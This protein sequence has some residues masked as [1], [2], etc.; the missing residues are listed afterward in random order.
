[1][2]LLSLLLQDYVGKPFPRVFS[3]QGGAQRVLSLPSPPCSMEGI[4][5]IHWALLWVTQKLVDTYRP[6]D[7]HS[8][9]MAVVKVTQSTDHRRDTPGGYWMENMEGKQSICGARKGQR[10][11]QAAKGSLT[12][13]DQV[14][15]GPEFCQLQ[16]SASCRRQQN[17]WRK[18]GV[19][20]LRGVEVAGADAED[21]VGPSRCASSPPALLRDHTS[22]P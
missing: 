8:P 7:C 5:M 9:G 16:S 19:T 4:H 3:C 14:E 6:Q 21:S 2:R 22:L 1:M 12:V 20:H 11:A 18:G 15:I 17:A 13:P 10:G